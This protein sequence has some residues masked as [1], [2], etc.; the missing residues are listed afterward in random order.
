M[1]QTTLGALK[2]VLAELKPQFSCLVFLSSLPPHPSPSLS[3]ALGSK[4]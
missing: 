3:P 1:E 4:P 2:E